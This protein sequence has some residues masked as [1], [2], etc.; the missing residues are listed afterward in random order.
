MERSDDSNLTSGDYQTKLGTLHLMKECLG[1]EFYV[2]DICLFLIL[3]LIY[4]YFFFILFIFIVKKG[5]EG[6]QRF[7]IS[8]YQGY[9]KESKSQHYFELFVNDL[10]YNHSCFRKF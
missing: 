5:A 6:E 2:A 8:K 1:G 9:Q 7:F 4:F 10:T 3:I